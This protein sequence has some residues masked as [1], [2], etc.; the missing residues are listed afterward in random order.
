MVGKEIEISHSDF[1]SSHLS[2]IKFLEYL[3]V[4]IMKHHN[5]INENNNCYVLNARPVDYCL[6]LKGEHLHKKKCG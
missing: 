1:H 4:A 2:N 5:G 3:Q 6:S